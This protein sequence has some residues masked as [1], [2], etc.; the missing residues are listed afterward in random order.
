MKDNKKGFIAV[1]IVAIIGIIVWQLTKKP[2]EKTKKDY[3]D[4]I[5]NNVIEGNNPN[6][7]NTM[8]GYDL[9]YLKAW[10]DAIE[11]K[12]SNFEYS[13]KKYLTSSGTVT[14]GGR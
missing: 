7:Y 4:N 14:A 9:G 5:F 6:E 11:A 2:K 10:S 13:G 8:M 12:I 3:L 1:G